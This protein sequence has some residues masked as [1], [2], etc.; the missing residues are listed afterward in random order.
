MYVLLIARA[1]KARMLH[2]ELKWGNDGLYENSD[3]INFNSAPLHEKLSDREYQVLYMI[4]RGKRLKDIAEELS[5]SIKTI[6]S[7]RTRIL[8]KLNVK[9]N[10][11]LARYAFDNHIIMPW[12]RTDNITKGNNK[13][14]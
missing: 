2:C 7:Y 6:S 14:E 13:A 5:L 3:P 8:E 4:V 11:E 9:S 12:E 1:M 10:V